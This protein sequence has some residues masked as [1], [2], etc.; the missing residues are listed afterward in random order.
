MSRCGFEIHL[1]SRAPAS[2]NEKAGYWKQRAGFNV[3][4][5]EGAGDGHGMIW[6]KDGRCNLKFLQY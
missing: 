5:G 6:V 4:D 1:T 3:V 2:L